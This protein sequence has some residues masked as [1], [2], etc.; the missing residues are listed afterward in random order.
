MISGFLITQILI[1]Q[2]AKGT[3]T[4]VGF[5]ERRVRRIFPALM[6]VLVSVLVAGWFV[7]FNAEYMD[8]ITHSLA[9]SLFVSNLLLYSQVGYFAQSSYALPLLH[10]WSLGIEE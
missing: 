6:V 7:L 9:G 2:N 3:F 5:Y 10:L 8:L 4:Y 1:E